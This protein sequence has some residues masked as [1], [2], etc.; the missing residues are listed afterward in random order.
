MYLS[1]ESSEGSILITSPGAS[2]E[3]SSLVS[4]GVG[5]ATAGSLANSV[6]LAGVTA[7]DAEMGLSCTRHGRTLGELFASVIRLGKEKKS[8]IVAVNRGEGGLNV[9]VQDIKAEVEEIF[10][11]VAAAACVDK[12]LGD[13]FNVEVVVVKSKDDA[14]TVRSKNTPCLFSAILHISCCDR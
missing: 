12:S 3:S 11:S 2:L 8:L 10:E 6:V 4:R 5:A 13:Y 7:A 1:D 9:N 14:S